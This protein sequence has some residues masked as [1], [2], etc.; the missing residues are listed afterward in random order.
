MWLSPR[1]IR[2]QLC[3][4]NFATVKPLVSATISGLEELRQNTGL[5]EKRITE[6]LKENSDYQDISLNLSDRIE[7]EVSSLKISYLENII[8]NLT[9]YRLNLII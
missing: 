2:L 3:T 9:D 1:L 8:A 7:S 6:N 5:N 4:A